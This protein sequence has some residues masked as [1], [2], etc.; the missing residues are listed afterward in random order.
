MTETTPRIMLVEDNPDHA[1]YI[2]KGLSR[3]GFQVDWYTEGPSA[4]A[5][6]KEDPPD[7]ILLDI[8]LPDMH[9]LDVL[10]ELKSDNRTLFVPVIVVT[11]Y[12]TLQLNREKEM[13]MT[14]GATDF[15]KKPFKVD[16][17]ATTLRKILQL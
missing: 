8:M 16:E 5:K 12:A 10:R 13:A 4:L 1:F 11:A 3:R 7:A 9:G 14:Y 2:Q 15:F 6:A 17:L